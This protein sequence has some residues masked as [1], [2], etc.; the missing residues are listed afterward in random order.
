MA[1]SL[2]T[3]VPMVTR[4]VCITAAWR[5]KEEDVMDIEKFTVPECVASTYEAINNQLSITHNRVKNVEL[6]KEMGQR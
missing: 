2:S 5:T 3:L 6:M 4:E 1:S